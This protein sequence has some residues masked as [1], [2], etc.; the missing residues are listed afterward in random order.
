M[1]LLQ[2]IEHVGEEIAKGIEWP[3][4]HAAKLAALIGDGLKDT[5]AVKTAIVQLVQKAEGV[6]PDFA[7]AIT[8]D[9]LNIGADLKCLGDVQT[10]FLYFKGTFLPVIEKAYADLKKDIA[11]PE[12]PAPIVPAAS[13]PAPAIQPGPG[14]HNVVPA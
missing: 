1:N 4:K 12:T 7:A 2:G 14:L 6:S 9:G 10:F 13:S 11:D 3:F 5:P 8:G